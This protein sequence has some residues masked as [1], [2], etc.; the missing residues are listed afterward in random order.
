[1]AEK[2]RDRM[3]GG[4]A[5]VFGGSTAV[6][7]DQAP[8][9]QEELKPPV[10]LEAQVDEDEKSVRT[11]KNSVSKIVPAQSQAPVAQTEHKERIQ[12]FNLQIPESLHARLKYFVDNHALRH[13][14][15]TKIIL[16]GLENNLR[17]LEIRAGIRKEED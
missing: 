14:S 3:K 7:N 8:E 9:K 11:D 12:P 6:V 17:A 10:V 15:M 16:N 13:E 2:N 5:M 4:L 1:M